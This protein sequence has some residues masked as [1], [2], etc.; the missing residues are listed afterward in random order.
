MTDRLKPLSSPRVSKM[1]A[2]C[3][4]VML[5]ACAE[6]DPQQ[7][8]QAGKSLYDKG[9]MESARVQ[10]KNALQINPKLADAYYGLA[11]LEEKK[12][13][14]K[15]MFG[16]L[17]E[18]VALDPNHLDAQVKLGQLY[19]LQGQLDKA[20]EAATVA[21]KLNPADINALIFQSALLF[22]EGKNAEALQQIQ[23]VL[24]KDAG[25]SDAIVS[26]V[27]ILSADKRYD[28]SLAALNGSIE[29]NPDNIAL[30]LMKIR[31]LTELKQFDEVT[32]DFEKLVALHPDN[33]T[34][35]NSQIDLLVGI[36]KPEQ[37]EKA[38]NDA[39]AKHPEDVD[40]KLKLVSLIERR[41]AVQAETT[42]KEFVTA[43]PDDIQLK[44]RFARFYADRGRPEDELLILNE[45]VT[46]DATGKDGLAAK[47]RLA[48]LA[49]SKGDKPAAEKLV[50]E[51]LAIDAGNSTGL[52]LRAGLRIDSKDADGAISDLRIVLRDQPN[53]DRAMVMMAQAYIT[54]GETEVAESHWRKA[55]EVNPAN[56]S[57]LAPMAGQLI[58][59]NDIARAEEL[60]DKAMKTSPSNPALLELL[61]QVKAAKKDWAGADAAV[62]ELKKLPQS[63]VSAGLWGG[64]LAAQ[65]GHYDEAIGSYK[66]VLIVQP[67]QARAL[68]AMANAY[69]AAG[70]RQELIVYLKGFLQDHPD[71]L[72]TYSLLAS[73]YAEE[74]QWNDA[75]KVLRDA[76]Q[77]APDNLEYKLRLVGIV[78]RGDE[79]KAEA[80]LTEYANASPKELRLK[81]RLAGF[82]IA[83]KR[84][85]DAELVLKEVIAADPSGDEGQAARIQLA[86]VALRQK[87]DV[88]AASALI[89]EVL[90]IDAD[91]TEALLL[92]GGLRMDAKDLA[93]AIA[94]LQQLL[95]KRPDADRALLMLAQAYLQ[96][97]DSAAAEVQWQKA[98]DINPSN[99]QALQSLTAQMR[100][101]GE[102]GLAQTLVEKAFKASPTNPQIAEL[103]VQFRVAKKDWVGAQTVV[104]ELKK[105]PQNEGAGNML[106]GLLAG[107]QGHYPEAIKSYKEVLA[108]QPKAE[109]AI[110]GLISAYEAAGQRKDA[111]AYLKSFLQKNPDSIA[112]HNALGLV[113]AAEKQ[114]ADA[115]KILHETLKLDP[116]SVSTYR[117]M[118]GVLQAQGKSAEIE[119]LY[120]KALAE[121]PD[122]PEFQME[123][124]KYCEQNQKGSEAIAIYKALTQK[125][126]GNDEVA[127]NLADLLVS[128]S[129]DPAGI[130]QATVLVE[131][132]K[133]TAN[134]YFLDTYGW[135]MFKSGDTEKAVAALKKSAAAAPNLA[136]IRYHLAEAYQ[137]AGDKSAASTELKKALELAEKQG[138]FN[139]IEQAKELLKQLGG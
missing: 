96:K 15:S 18:T 38:L 28:E 80:L 31:I 11:L 127:N 73:A 88:P 126:P 72:L 65:R 135:V 107:A 60:L 139:G 63:Q 41:D 74:K 114:W 54:K 24:A 6:E 129:D 133:D 53:S 36:G 98:L 42:L 61:V 109:Q 113:Y 7:F 21:L 12:Q 56:L 4:L 111:V 44:A 94:D 134:P 120:R 119:T 17:Q 46:A 40:F 90:K 32:A 81:A 19:M 82:Y 71:S 91:N 125:Y 84:I 3:L 116:K 9:D 66:D 106:N 43:R 138:S 110:S 115:D 22:R 131:R 37:A 26:L 5:S 33:K 59:R 92:R 62:A 45:I 89:D 23:Q 93:G 13:D 100:Q 123:L 52:L 39:I 57:A 85:P 76:V 112:A 50:D 14:W 47:V 130:M 55:L 64:L 95:Q 101:R 69:Q 34:L 70:K 103:L 35:R 29:S 10:F 77:K 2:I 16:A 136:A 58:K 25:N 117:V 20:K 102:A 30:W 1:L 78:E 105:Q 86:Q 48:E 97:G 75:E 87:N 104:D 49:W 121:S 51:V 108:K 137:K 79:S 118:A 68:A 124:A 128:V 27:S 132:F 8:I 122:V 67:N 83:R 99:V